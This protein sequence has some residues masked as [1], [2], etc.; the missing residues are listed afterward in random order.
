MK[1][2]PY[3]R[4][5]LVVTL[6]GLAQAASAGSPQPPL[7]VYAAQAKAADPAF[8]GFSAER[9]ETLFKSN[10]S[11]GKPDT[12]S[13]STC[14]TTDPKKPGQTRAGKPIDPMAVSVSPN[15]YTDLEKTEK[16]FGRNCRNVL[17][18]DCAATE[19]GDFITFM[20]TQ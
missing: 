20:L 7:E 12:P 17:G 19:K 16:W 5:W 10:F 8:S 4:A 2:T 1:A 9:G 15:R 3:L 14:H 13:C 18:R 6:G 11:G